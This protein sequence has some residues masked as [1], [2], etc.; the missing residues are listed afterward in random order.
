[1]YPP[2]C[3]ISIAW[4]LWDFLSIKP[5]GWKLLSH[6]VDLALELDGGLYDYMNEFIEDFSGNER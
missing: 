5:L 6:S 2:F 1:M 3:E 4:A